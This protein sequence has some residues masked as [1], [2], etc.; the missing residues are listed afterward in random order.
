MAAKDT[1]AVK[2]KATGFKEK[3][4]SKEQEAAKEES[5]ESDQVWLCCSE[6]TLKVLKSYFF[7]GGRSLANQ[8]K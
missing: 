1:K 5:D 8:Y 7:K 3:P 4:I 2:R 6:C